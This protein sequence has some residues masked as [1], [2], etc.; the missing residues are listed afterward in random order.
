VLLLSQ[1]DSG[2]RLRFLSYRSVS[3]SSRIS[4]ASRTKLGHTVECIFSSTACRKPSTD[5]AK[6]FSDFSHDSVD[7]E[8]L[9]KARF[10]F[11]LRTPCYQ[12]FILTPF[13]LLLIAFINNFLDGRF[14]LLKT[15]RLFLFD[16]GVTRYLLQ[17]QYNFSDDLLEHIIPLVSAA[18]RTASVG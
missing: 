10:L 1:N 5:A 9:Q 2:A 7:L 18:N 3:I 14:P 16:N 17:C 6:L 15:H 4:T 12:Y 8:R 11:E 13:L